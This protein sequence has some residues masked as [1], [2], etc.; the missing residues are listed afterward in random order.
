[1]TCPQRH[2]E[3]YGRHGWLWK[4]IYSSLP[5]VGTTRNAVFVAFRERVVGMYILRKVQVF[6]L[7][8]CC[9]QY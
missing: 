9:C 4:L 7:I 2:E 6:V 3:W 1:M 5:D 8:H